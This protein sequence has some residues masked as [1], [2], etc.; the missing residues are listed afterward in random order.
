MKTCVALLRGINVGGKNSLPM[1]E[2]VKILELAGCRNVR[3]YIQ[4]G[5]GR[6]RPGC[7]SNRQKLEHGPEAS[8]NGRGGWNLICCVRGIGDILWFYD[9]E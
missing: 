4:S 2:L 1:K 3:T 8:G 5:S 9:V 6:K 7:S